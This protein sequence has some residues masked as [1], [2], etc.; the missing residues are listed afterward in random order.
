MEIDIE[1]NIELDKT[2]NNEEA[3]TTNESLEDVIPDH[4]LDLSFILNTYKSCDPS[5]EINLK[6]NST[7]E[8]RKPSIL[9]QLYY[10][11]S[12]LD[13]TEAKFNKLET[14]ILERKNEYK[15]FLDDINNVKQYKNIFDKDNVDNLVS[16][17]NS[18]MTL[19]YDEVKKKPKIFV[20]KSLFIKKI[21]DDPTENILITRPR[22]WG[23][24][25]NMDMLSSFL[26]I[27]SSYDGKRKTHSTTLTISPYFNGQSLMKKLKI[28]STLDEI[29]YTSLTKFILTENKVNKIYKW[30]IVELVNLLDDCFSS[31]EESSIIK[32]TI[33]ELENNKQI[34]THQTK[35]EEMYK[36]YFTDVYNMIKASVSD[37]IQQ[38]TTSEDT[39]NNFIRNY[40]NCMEIDFESSTRDIIGKKNVNKSVNLISQIQSFPTMT[41]IDNKL[42]RKNGLEV[43]DAY[44]EKKRS[45]EK[46]KKDLFILLVE[47]VEEVVK[48]F[49]QNE[50]SSKFE[51]FETISNS[52]NFVKRELGKNPVI[53]ITF[54][55][56]QRNLDKF[57]EYEK[58]ITKLSDEIKNNDYILNLL[59]NSK[60]SLFES[61]TEKSPVFMVSCID[62]IINH[63]GEHSESI[64]NVYLQ[65]FKSFVIEILTILLT[66]ESSDY[67]RTSCEIWIKNLLL[68]STNTDSHNFI[69]IYCALLN[70][71]NQKFSKL[72][73]I[74]IEIT[75]LAI[76]DKLYYNPSNTKNRFVKGTSGF[77]IDSIMEAY[78]DHLYLE[79]CL[80]QGNKAIFQKYLNDNTYLKQNF[81]NSIFFL[82]EM[83]YNHWGKKVFILIDEYDAP[84]NSAMIYDKKFN[85]NISKYEEIKVMLQMF[86]QKTMKNNK[87]V[88]KSIMT[89]ILR[90]AKGDLFSGLNNFTEYGMLDDTRYGEFFGFT[91]EEL[92]K[93]LIDFAIVPDY[94]N[95]FQAYMKKWYDGYTM[96][97]NGTYQQLYNA[98]SVITSFH[99]K[100]FDKHW[101]DTGDTALL[102]YCF[103]NLK[104]VGTE[105]NRIQNLVTKGIFNDK[106]ESYVN[107]KSIENNPSSFFALLLYSG[108]LS[109]TANSDE[110][111]IP[112]EEV[113]KYFYSPNGLLDSW[114]MAR[115]VNMVTLVN[116]MNSNFHDCEKYGEAIKTHLLDKMKP[117]DAKREADFQVLLGLFP[118]FY[119]FTCSKYKYNTFAEF[120]TKLNKRLDLL[121][122]PIFVETDPLVIQEYKL[123]NNNTNIYK[124]LEAILQIYNENYLSILYDKNNL[125]LDRYKRLKNII[126]RAM[127]FSNVNSQWHVN[128][129]QFN[130]KLDTIIEDL[131]IRV[132]EVLNLNSKN[133]YFK[134]VVCKDNKTFTLIPNNVD[135]TEEFNLGVASFYNSDGKM[136]DFK[137]CKYY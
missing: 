128:I 108:Y 77:I 38:Y 135:I 20:D 44:I 70:N 76:G 57:Y 8:V 69:N 85:E 132:D 64:I 35:L 37:K 30:N 113:R 74:I 50:D 62:K 122:D 107:P 67:A 49:K 88:R 55:K 29:D 120:Y 91:E 129:I 43:Y 6:S 18:F 25:I 124:M 27:E 100:S 94:R 47:A 92:R 109:R 81:E 51:V 28:C 1:T 126:I 32:T 56:V 31:N 5:N 59:S 42:E 131:I 48:S 97:I 73:E 83:L 58:L 95:L 17:V 19:V 121:A 116:E 119:K 105:N 93:E 101:I 118:S 71:C 15:T 60:I 90:V 123:K 125:L 75:K 34:F 53:F 68:Y 10:L 63:I 79:N 114:F 65:E 4:D 33:E 111:K 115:G 39:L 46:Q 66:E 13:N 112:N 103:N 23:K 36:K 22:R 2:K 26:K 40:K 98:W 80:N 61:L 127:V 110:Y 72:L 86:F 89:G 102:E 134:A 106:I 21:L 117:E 7:E 137:K 41:V 45:L 82:S 87:Y 78:N 3:N 104:M 11:F 24:T 130:H 12:C 16:S 133:E 136:L 96:N 14:Q 84:L 99:K 54:S 9:D 52:Y